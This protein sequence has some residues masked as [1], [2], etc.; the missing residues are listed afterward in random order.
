MFCRHW[1]TNVAISELEKELQ[2]QRRQQEK[3]VKQIDSG[4][5]GR[6]ERGTSTCYKS[7]DASVL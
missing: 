4:H 2:L 3:V 1:F 7:E 6:D 5:G